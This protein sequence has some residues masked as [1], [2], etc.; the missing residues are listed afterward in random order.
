M[1]NAENAH[2]WQ[3]DN[4]IKKIR[5]SAGTELL[6]SP[7]AWQK[8]PWARR[9]FGRRPKAG[10][11]LWVKKPQSGPL[12]TCI[13]MV[14]PKIVQDL[15]NLVVIE[16][17]LRIK[18][19]VWCGAE[20]RH[21]CGRHRARG[22]L[23]LKRGAFLEYDHCHEWGT[24]D[25]VSPDY[26]FILEK[27]TRLIYRYHN[28]MTP[29]QL[30]FKTRILAAARSSANIMTVVDAGRTKDAEVN[31]NEAV[32]LSG[33]NA[34]AIMR[35]RLVG[36]R[37]SRI[38]AESSIVAER[39]SKGH[40]DCQGLLVGR[41]ASVKLTPQIICKTKEADLTHEASLGKISSEKLAYLNTRGLN[42]REAT[43]LIITGFLQN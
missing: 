15:M 33:E 18:S 30:D 35:L 22:K 25:L 37:K 20:K 9:F 6:P 38:R 43:D 4:K 17:G 13:T 10:Y 34:Q 39:K 24:E 21:L 26:E 28:V 23:V 31:I 32:I 29:K 40:L 36:R 14:S 42:R 19:S 41:G 2:Y 12:I 16:P 3:I 1:K 7:A 8:F 27:D 5:A 11:F